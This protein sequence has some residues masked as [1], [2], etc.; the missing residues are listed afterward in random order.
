[1]VAGLI[2]LA[3]LNF[4]ALFA[5]IFGMEKLSHHADRL[6]K[7]QPYHPDLAHWNHSGERLM[8]MCSVFSWIG[9]AMFALGWWRQVHDI[10]PDHSNASPP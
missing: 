7:S 3:V 1:M 6:F 10:R 4:P 9:F 5:E 2:S 8:L